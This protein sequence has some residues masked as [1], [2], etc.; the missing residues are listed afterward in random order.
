MARCETS[1]LYWTF[2]LEEHVNIFV[3]YTQPR[4][5]N[6]VEHSG[7]KNSSPARLSMTS[8]IFIGIQKRTTGHLDGEGFGSEPDAWEQSGRRGER[9]M[10]PKVEYGGNIYSP[11]TH[12]H[13]AEIGP[14]EKS[15]CGGPAGDVSG[16]HNIQCRCTGFCQWKNAG[17]SSLYSTRELRLSACEK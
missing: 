7:L 9:T 6:Q 4:L 11:H 1:S 12:T 14:L 13:K 2:T 10:P 5:Y 15:A 17:L 8:A 3:C 16:I